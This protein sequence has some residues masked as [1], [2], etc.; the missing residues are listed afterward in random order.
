MQIKCIKESKYIK[1]LYIKYYK[2]VKKIPKF[3]F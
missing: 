3:D 2:F 1:D